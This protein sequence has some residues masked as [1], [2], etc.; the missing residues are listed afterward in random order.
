[1]A[2][3]EAWRA[4]REQSEAEQRLAESERSRRLGEREDDEQLALL[5]APLDSVQLVHHGDQHLW[6]RGAHPLPLPRSGPV[7]SSPSPSS[8]HPPADLALGVS[9]PQATQE[10]AE[11]VSPLSPPLISTSQ[12]P[13]ILPHALSS[14]TASTR[15]DPRPLSRLAFSLL[16]SALRAAQPCRVWSS[17][18][19]T[20]SGQ[21]QELGWGPLEGSGGSTTSTRR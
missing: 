13:A 5:L 12:P 16:K 4:S 9:R 6:P 17:A 14:S 3:A 2:I 8:S 11:N 19:R 18:R 15:R 10:R 20:V 1:M 7:S 21:A